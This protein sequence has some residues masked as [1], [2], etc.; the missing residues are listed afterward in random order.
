M[1]AL[2]S[3]DNIT[4][5]FESVFAQSERGI[6]YSSRSKKNTHRTCWESYFYTN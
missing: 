6:Y 5:R 2:I 3:G 4:G 1:S